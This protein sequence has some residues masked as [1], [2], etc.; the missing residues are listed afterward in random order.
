VSIA[1]INGANGSAV[2][3][4][5]SAG[6][7]ITY[8]VDSAS[9]SQYNMQ[10]FIAYASP[11]IYVRQANGDAW[12]KWQEKGSNSY[13]TDA[14]AFDCATAISAFDL[15]ITYTPINTATA[16]ASN[17]PES[18]AGT[19]ITYKVSTTSLIYNFQEYRVILG[20]K[21]YRRGFNSDGT[22]TAWVKFCE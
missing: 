13:I 18:M 7:L 15:G 10:M 3:P 16:T 20:S 12:T 19:L 11:R 1:Y 22:P 9:T 6:T 21:S 17:A 4:S 5:K 2:A 8:K 14:N